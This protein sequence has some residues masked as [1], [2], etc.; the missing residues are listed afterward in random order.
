[1]IEEIPTN[2]Y[3]SILQVAWN[4]EFDNTANRVPAV[5]LKQNPEG[6]MQ[7]YLFDTII[8]KFRVKLKTWHNI[9]ILKGPVEPGKVK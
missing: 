4:N 7:F 8:P 9:E 2:K 6:A 5:F 1:M 3:V